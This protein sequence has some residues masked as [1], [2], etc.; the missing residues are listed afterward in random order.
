MQEYIL[1]KGDIGKRV[2][3]KKEDGLF[4]D[5]RKSVGEEESWG[6]G[7]IRGNN[8]EDLTGEEIGVVGVGNDVKKK[9]DEVIACYSKVEESRQNIKRKGNFFYR[10]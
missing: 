9:G 3:E 6:E 5:D 8:E 4:Y 2:E 1:R 10:R 7:K